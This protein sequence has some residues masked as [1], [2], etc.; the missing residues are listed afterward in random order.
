MAHLNV[1]YNLSAAI[2]IEMKINAHAGYNSSF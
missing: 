1:R 2:Q